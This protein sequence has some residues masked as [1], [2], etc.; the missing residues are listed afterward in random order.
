MTIFFRTCA[1]FASAR[2]LA[3]VIA[4]LGALAL[5]GCSD[6]ASPGPADPPASA[7]VGAGG[8]GGSGGGAGGG[9]DGGRAGACA[10]PPADFP[11]DLPIESNGQY[12]RVAEFPL[13][14]FDS[15]PVRIYLPEGYDGSRPYPVVYFTDGA[16]VFDGGYKTQDAME[17]LAGSGVIEP[18]IL[19][20]IYNPIVTRTFELTPDEDA[21]APERSGG[22][23]DFAAQVVQRVKPFV[24]ATF[25]TRCD[26]EHTTIAGFS[27]GGLM[28]LHML[29]RDPDVFGRGICE[30]PSFWW[31]GKSILDRF[32]AHQGPLPLRIWIDVGTK[33]APT[34]EELANFPVDAAFL[35]H[36]HAIR[37]GRD[38]AIDK[39]MTLGDGLGY[40]EQIDGPHTPGDV[41]VRMPGALAFALS[42]VNLVGLTPTG[43]AFHVWH[44]QILAPPN[45]NPYAI[46][47]T[48]SF[49]TRFDDPYVITWPN[50]LLE[51]SSASEPVATIDAEGII[52]AVA[53][54]TASFTGSLMGLDGNDAIEVLPA[55]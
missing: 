11:M 31:N 48:V 3:V 20:A 49:E 34:I 28:C 46:A 38:L 1:A 39:G 10:P 7:G 8:A 44:E 36:S 41:G 33:E 12:R 19:V 50:T 4:A 16:W 47:S 22:G 30:S 55:Q 23:D 18:H 35:E 53:P 17:A 2:G 24:D 26:R 27:L 6:A 21:T 9:G 32:A 25:A 54:G 29:M 52:D 43:H 13:E 14:G 51:L 40:H 45:A 15:R 42:D 37:E 5:S